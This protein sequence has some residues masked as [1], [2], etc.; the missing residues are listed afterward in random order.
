M[1][2][3]QS[4]L[5]QEKK[6]E[7]GGRGVA[8]RAG[9]GPIP[10][11]GAGPGAGEPCPGRFGTGHSFTIP[12]RK[13]AKFNVGS[14]AICKLSGTTLKVVPLRLHARPCAAVTPEGGRYFGKLGV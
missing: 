9:G 11:G 8:G 1:T 2:K 5:R 12:R 13:T 10:T 6:K 7:S 4:R 3:D 14:P